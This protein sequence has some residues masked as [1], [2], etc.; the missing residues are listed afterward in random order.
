[1]RNC[2]TFIL[3][4]SLLAA[5]SREA[6]AGEE[7]V[8]QLDAAFSKTVQPF[9]E[10]YCVKCHGGAR[11]EA[12]FD[13]TAYESRADVL[14]DGRRWGLV[15]EQLEDKEMPPRKAKLHPSSEE[16][17]QV[18]AWFQTLRNEEIQRHA[19]DPGLV[20]A[21]RLSN[22][23][24]DYTVRDLTGVDLKPTREFP[25]DPTNMAGFDNSGES[26]VMSPALLKKYLQATR[27]VANHLYLKP[28]GFGFAPFPMLVETDRDKFCVQQIIDLY[29]RQNTDYADYFQA[30]WRFKHRA[31]LGKLEATLAEIASSARV[32]AK[33]L[34]TVWTALEETGEEVGPAVKL[35][36]M[37]RE[38]PAPNPAEPNL[39][40]PGCEQMREY[41][42]QL[43]K[44][45]EPRFLNITAGQIGASRQPLLIWKNVQYATHRRTFD[46]AQLQVEGE[47][48]PVVPEI[49]EPGAG[50]DFGPGRTRLINNA[51]GDPDL[52]VPAGERARYE[53]AFARFCSVFPDMFYK[54]ERGRNYFDTSK[55]RGRYLSAG[56]HN[57]MGYFRDDQP[58]YELLLDERQ[59]Q[60]LD[61]LWYEMD[62]VASTT[63]RMYAQFSTS[64]EARGRVSIEDDTQAPADS[65]A[66]EEDSG[67]TS[68]AKIRQVEASYLK[69]AAGGNEVGIQAIRDYFSW[70]NRTIR[71]VEKARIDAEP[72][73][74]E[75]LLQFATRAYRRPLAEEEKAELRAF[76]DSCRKKGGLDHLAAIRESLVSVLM[77]PDV[78][79]RIDLVSDQPG[80]QP[81]SDYDLA[82]RLSYF[83]W[84][85][86]PDA[87]LLAH[88]AAGD[89][90][91]PEVL[92]AQTKR[93]LKDPRIRAFALEFGG[94]WL[95]FRRFEG[96]STVDVE[97]FP[98]FTSELGEAMFEEP[99][100]F[101]LDVF[102]NDRS[103]LDFLY[104]RDTF[105]NPVLARHYGMKVSSQSPKEWIRIEDAS[106]FGRG[107]ILPMA[108]FLTR[109]APGLRTSPVK[110]GN[111]IVKNILGEHIPAP[112]AD[113]PE[114]PR[115]EAKLDLPLPEML[116]RHR[117]DPN[118]AG[119]H[120]RFDALGLVFEG[121][122]PVGQRR[123]QDLGGRPVVTRAIFPGGS[124]GDGIEGLKHYL[125]EQRQEDFVNN[126]SGKLISYALGRTL[127]FSDE[128]LI[129]EI[130]NKL[131]A[132]G[133]R[134]QSIVETIVS[135]P[136]FFTKRGRTDLVGK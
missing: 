33:Y 8:A 80:I 120:D 52:R 9:L 18:I 94:N 91:R 19:G 59:Q 31:A 3:I 115:D 45:V 98:S 90:R 105:V 123:E 41:V 60:E 89:L 79:Y 65:P 136:Q 85:S 71:S 127:M 21:R 133:Y 4:L 56:F 24:F 101:L 99:I 67:V 14:K 2:L 49:S 92:A 75:A 96:I 22:A 107:G 87:E 74:L 54:A 55:D 51:P 125:R 7:I 82:S 43:R 42:V 130:R 70:I 109:N 131:A 114:L 12:E 36:A 48:K 106:S 128:L 26:L 129:Q 10:N 17:D 111:W 116:A 15:L 38:L 108:A 11:T 68:E 93:M 44:K 32:S 50:G 84:S 66:P 97:R 77:S 64:S 86:I 102:Q 57:V 25:M 40:R 13:L 112:P 20:L 63:A 104:A 23:E 124:E 100:R 47:T 119:C 78:C 53:A 110:R 135:S 72:T 73:H 95:D 88:A 113:V 118:C 29:R 103:V 58:L 126:L 117:A 28:K 122:N 81:L 121:F 34:G 5:V 27:G 1:M 61:A 6:R 30:A 76:Y 69:L 134:F 132:N 16:R 46:P 37:W 39:A 62:F 35:Q 83:L